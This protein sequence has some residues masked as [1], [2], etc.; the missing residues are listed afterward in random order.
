MNNNLIAA[1]DL[2]GTKIYTVLADVQGKILAFTREETKSTQGSDAIIRQMASTVHTVFEQAGQSTSRLSAVGVCAAG[3]FD[4][5][6][7]IMIHSPN[8]PGWDMVPLERELEEQFGVP[9]IVENDANAQ[10]LGEARFGAGR[11]ANDQI[12]I[13]V[14]TGI[15]A[16]L[17]IDGNIYRGS[18]GFAGEA[19]HMVVKPDGPVCG[20]GRRGCLETISSG[21][22]IAR[23]AHNAVSD[24]KIRTSLSATLARE[25]KLTTPHVFQAAQLGD[26]V[27][28]DIL[29]EAIH[30][31]GIGLVN[32]V[33]LLNPEMIIIGGGVAEAGEV[34]LHPLREMIVH[35]AIPPS[36]AVITLK[37]AEL[38]VEAGV[39]GMLCALSDV[40][41]SEEE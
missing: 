35:N 20:C 22:A 2:G 40:C 30:Y 3:F 36:A 15:G 18:K 27:A 9:V 25:G 5:Q 14:S 7:K 21:T 6:K 28:K 4:W 16:G 41:A 11:G 31:L 1:I 12:F 37:K 8:L 19:G 10:A 32:L 34:F 26:T 38:G 24:G 33:N 23:A 13:T 39:T 17:I 29:A